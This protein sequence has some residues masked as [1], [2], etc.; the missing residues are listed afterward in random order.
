MSIKDIQSW[1]N[2]E[3]L[4]SEKVKKQYPLLL[5]IAVLVLVYIFVGYGATEQQHHITDLKKQMLDSKYEYMTTSA[6]LV[7]TT[8]QSQVATELEQ[9]GSRLK[10]SSTPPVKL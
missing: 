9:R 2:G 4:R 5:L 7:R 1:L 6:E 10:E 3:K 8:K